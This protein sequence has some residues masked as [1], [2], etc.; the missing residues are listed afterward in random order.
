M[1]KVLSMILALSMALSLAACGAKDETPSTDS[2]G[3]SDSVA[4]SES[5]A[6]SISGKLVVYST[7]G[8]TELYTYVDGFSAMY[9]DVEVEVVSGGIGELMAR[10]Q[11]EAGAPQADVVAGGLSDSDGNMHEAYF[12]PYVSIYDDELMDGFRSNGYYNYHGASATALCVNND[13]EAELGF[14][15]TSY[16]DLLRPE[17]KG[18]VIM[19]D[20]NS[21]SS[22]WN[23]VCNIMSCF[24][25]DS[26]EAWEFIAGLLEN[27]V[28]ASSS[29][30]TFNSVADGEYVVGL[31]YEAGVNT[32][33]AEGADNIRLVFP[34]EGTSASGSAV[35]V[36]KNCN[37]PDAAK[38]FVDFM[39]SAKAQ[40][41]LLENGL[42]VRGC[43]TTVDYPAD[44]LVPTD[45][46][47][48]VAR[49]VDQLVEGKEAILEHWNELYATIVG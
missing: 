34:T 29:S 24:G 43:N 32:A 38:A 37:N 40:E 19:A 27:V 23:Q 22:A 41:L 4:S 44:M 8:E 26:D 39:C 47:D 36:I 3:A 2:T 10:V 33:K 14:E 15:I 17:L 9:P 28:V 46:I 1:K 5:E 21:S 45:D 42:A 11:A 12:E 31:T 13:L 18:K 35:A 48:W 30:A 6:A 7:F 49:P 20:P 16:A 25:Y